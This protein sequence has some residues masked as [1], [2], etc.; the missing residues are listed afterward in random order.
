M[1]FDKYQGAGNDFVIVDLRAVTDAEREAA[2]DPAVVRALCDR[3]FGIGGDGVLALLAPRTPDADARMRVLN[4]DGSEAE[5]CGNGIR[6]VVKHLYDTGLVKP[7]IAIDTGAGVLACDV[8]AIDGRARTVTVDMGRPRLLRA[9][10]PMTGPA[11]ERC[12]ASSRFELDQHRTA[13]GG[14]ALPA[15]SKSRP[16]GA[17]PRAR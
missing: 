12:V 1:R 16:A 15:G 13:T 11:D 9:E 4:A 2:Q 3:Q 5:M 10:I 7:R 6:C 14:G 8:D 17:N